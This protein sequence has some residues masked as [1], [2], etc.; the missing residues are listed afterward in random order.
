[1]PPT[2]ARP[3]RLLFCTL[4]GFGHVFPMLP[5]AVAAREA[6]HEVQFATGADAVPAVSRAGFTAHPVGTSI[7]ECISELAGGIPVTEIPDEVRPKLV[8]EAFSAVL[9]RYTIRDLTPIR[10]ELAPDLIVY[11]QWDL[12]PAVVAVAAGVPAVEFKLSRVHAPN[13]DSSRTLPPGDASRA[14][15]FSANGLSDTVVHRFLDIFPSSLQ[16]PAVRDDPRRLP[17]RPIAWADPGAGVPDWVRAERSRP[18]VYLTLGTT[19]QDVRALRTALVGLAKLDVDVLVAL[20]QLSGDGLPTGD[21]VHLTRWVDQT[22]VLRHADLVV[23]HGGSG[24]TLGTAGAGLPQ[25][26]LPQRGD[27]FS[28]ASAV[29]SAGVGRALLPAAV[30][31]E[32]VAEA[33]DALLGSAQYRQAA[34]AT[35]AEIE[36][37]PTPA[38]VLPRVVEIADSGERK[39]GMAYTAP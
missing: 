17:M 3:H 22:E 25:L 35:R 10:A 4:S 31:P 30:T 2:T 32:A 27:Q 28:Q 38:E 20:G 13:G 7:P 24:T 21:R 6:G 16:D 39:A 15:L 29:A 11:N 19:P 14:A 8:Y 33:V 34:A 37:M 5:L 36:A 23:H 18:L 26:I 9:P 1:M 12:G